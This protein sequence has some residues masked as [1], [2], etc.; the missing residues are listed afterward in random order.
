MSAYF[1]AEESAFAH[2]GYDDRAVL[3][4]L[5][6]R[7]KGT[8]PPVPFT[9]RT[10][11]RS[12][13]LQ[14]K[15]GLY[16]IDLKAKFPAARAGQHGYAYASVWSDSERSLD[17]LL[18]CYGPVQLYLNGEMM[19][20]SS[21]IDEIKPDAEVK[22]N[23]TFN[24]GWNRLF[25]KMKSTT[26]GFGCKIGADEAKVRILN[27]LSPFPERAGQSGWVYTA[28]AEADLFADGPDERLLAAEASSGLTWHPVQTWDAE[29]LRQPSL[30]RMYGLLPGKL[31]YAW[32]KLHQEKPGTRSVVL[33]GTTDGPLTVWV[34][35]TIAVER[36]HAGGFRHELELAAGS[37]DLLVRSGC[38]EQSWNFT[39]AVSCEGTPCRLALPVAVKGTSERWLYAGPLGSESAL[40]YKDVVSTDRVYPVGAELAANDHVYWRLD[41]PEAWIRPIYENA[42]LSNK[43]TVGSV[44]NYARWD[45]PLGVTVYG[46]LQSG[47][48]LERQDLIDYAVS[49]VQ[50]C[51][52]MY[53]YALW[54]REQYGFPAINQQL[55][56]MRMLDN[57]GS[58]GSAMLEAY[59][60]CGEDAA[61]VG[62]AEQIADFML[63]RLERKADGAF[64]RECP[65]EYSANTMWADDLY[66]ST[67][68]LCR[69]YR[70]TGCKRALDEAARQFLLFRNY[71]YMPEQQ[72]MSHV[73]DF[74][75]GVATSI[76]WGRGNGWTLFSLTEVLETLPSDHP[77]KAELLAF[78]NELCQ[79]Y[80]ALQAD[81]GLWHQVLNDA[82]AYEEAS[83]SAMF[84]YAFARGVRFGWLSQP[85]RYT[86]AAFKA[87]SGLTQVAID[88]HGNVHGVCSGSRY[89]FHADYYKYD[90]RTV[91]NDNHGIGIM[92]L[93]GTEVAKLKHASGQL[94]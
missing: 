70:L 42:M 62:I 31:A 66:M 6:D 50:A 48:W 64:Y 63:N 33:E 2:F 90:L 24:K 22:L 86:D 51:T 72:I 3:Q 46:L 18:A 69:Y 52:R 34:D 44:T 81:S 89:A 84:A 74:K 8:N 57:C 14:T 75:H 32:T 16:D 13:V 28:P 29:Q 60:E 41:Q 45:Y 61:I 47:R 17:L 87:W 73:F 49:H 80:A 25:L 77:D 37:Y 1:D 65:G 54:D 56:L 5:A 71:L 19:Y 20:R 59:Q 85:D 67:P 43:W 58:F 91:T 78:F 26:A 83:C 36:Q 88:R 94:L 23:V 21:V 68:F 4:L 92:M 10:F 53:A 27:V 93:A 38:T 30:E 11:F 39:L 9:F 12:G 55:V 7:Y 79:G 82:D 35:G 15:E 76:P 40:G